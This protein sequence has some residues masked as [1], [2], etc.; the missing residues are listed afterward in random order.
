[1]KDG[2]LPGANVQDRKPDSSPTI[3]AN[4]MIVW[5]EKGEKKG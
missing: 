4:T 1:M 3:T 2:V 5:E